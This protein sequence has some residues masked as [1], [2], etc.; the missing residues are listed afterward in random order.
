MA[1]T[2]MNIATWLA[3]SASTP[4]FMRIRSAF[5]STCRNGM[6]TGC[7]GGGAGTRNSVTPMASTPSTAISQKMPDMPMLFSSGEAI[8]R[9]SAKVSPMLPPTIAMALVRWRSRVRSAMQAV[10]A[11]EM[12]PMPCIARPMVMP[13]RVSEKAATSA[14]ATNSSSPATITGLRPTRS[15]SQPSGI[16]RKACIRP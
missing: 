4:T 6:R 7:G 16:W 1:G 5:S 8:T 14:P 2:T 13:A 9:D 12:A 11:A 3:C 10:M 15:D